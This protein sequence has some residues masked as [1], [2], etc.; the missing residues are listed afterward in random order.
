M[1]DQR[2]VILGKVGGLYGVHGWVKLWSFTEPVE[3]LL[4][5]R[6]METGGRALATGPAGGGP[7]APQRPGGPLRGLR[8]PR[9]GRSAG[10]RPA[11][12]VR[13]RCRSRGGRVLLGRPGRA[14]GGHGRA[15][16]SAGSERMMATG[17]NDVMVV[18]RRAGAAGAVP[19]RA[20]R[21]TRWTWPAAAWS[22]TGTRISEGR[23]RALRGR[24]A[25]PGGHRRARALRRGGARAGARP[26][27][28]RDGRTRASS[29]RTRTAAWTI[30]RM[31]AGRAW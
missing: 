21:G 18:A 13:E 9:C 19:A 7:A 31:A 14:R 16:G 15:C 26:A 29:R 12:G 30:G 24:D 20:V 3:N 8:G 5:Y 10:G 17:A 25:V 1:T 28:A 6:D 27:A 2:R 4:D 22:S 11:G 23:R